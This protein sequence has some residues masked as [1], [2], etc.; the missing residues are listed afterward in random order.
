[1]LHSEITATVLTLVLGE[2]LVCSIPTLVTA[3][4]QG[5]FSLACFLS[6]FPLY[7]S[8]ALFS[9]LLAPPPSCYA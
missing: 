7:F 5:S 2:P 8:F 9:D 6:S 1:M 4:T 3:E